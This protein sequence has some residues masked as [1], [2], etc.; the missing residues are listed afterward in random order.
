MMNDS[1]RGIQ[2][3]L[4]GFSHFTKQLQ[5]CGFIRFFKN[6]TAKAI[7][8]NCNKFGK[9]QFLLR[10]KNLSVILVGR[11]ITFALFG[12]LWVLSVTPTSPGLPG[13]ARCAT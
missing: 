2:F 11:V 9:K 13:R 1:F 12:V 7:N 5:L 3:R 10:G 8:G 6:R 4:N